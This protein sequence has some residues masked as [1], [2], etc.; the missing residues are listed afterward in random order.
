M[1]QLQEEKTLIANTLK[2]SINVWNATYVQYARVE[3]VQYINRQIFSGVKLCQ[4]C[5]LN[6]T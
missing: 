2:S 5:S 1:V 6:V 4:N 3:T